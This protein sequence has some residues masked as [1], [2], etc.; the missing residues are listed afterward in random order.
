MNLK[1][2]EK[3]IASFIKDRNLM[4]LRDKRSGAALNVSYS[5]YGLT[6]TTNKVGRLLYYNKAFLSSGKKVGDL[7]PSPHVY[8]EKFVP[9][10]HTST[11]SQVAEY[12]WVKKATHLLYGSDAPAQKSMN[13]VY[14]TASGDKSTSSTLNIIL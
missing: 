13:L 1:P 2:I 10:N 5:E 4:V 12:T 8:I 6:W 11:S 9:R 3:G 7:K 14:S